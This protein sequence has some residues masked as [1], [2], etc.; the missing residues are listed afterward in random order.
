MFCVP[1]NK[2]RLLFRMTQLTSSLPSESLKVVQDELQGRLDVCYAS[3]LNLQNVTQLGG[4]HLMR[5]CLKITSSHTCFL[6]PSIHIRLILLS[7]ALTI[8]LHTFSLPVFHFLSPPLCH[9]LHAFIL[10]SACFEE[11]MLYLSIKTKYGFS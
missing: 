11:H 8:F 5:L 9:L 4:H 7:P 2:K 1:S 3:C 10:L 6:P